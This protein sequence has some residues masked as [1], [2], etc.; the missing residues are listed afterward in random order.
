MVC[1]KEKHIQDEL[2]VL[3]RAPFPGSGGHP[4]DSCPGWGRAEALALGASPGELGR[5]P[6]RFTL[7]TACFSPASCWLVTLMQVQSL[8]GGRA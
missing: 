4:P 2:A 6:D 1:I 5:P 8:G 7:V 3:S